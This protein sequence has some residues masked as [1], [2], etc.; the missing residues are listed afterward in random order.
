MKTYQFEKDLM[1]G[2]KSR[3]R[4]K[5]ISR[6]KS[7]ARWLARARKDPFTRKAQAEGRVSRAHFKLEELDRRCRLLRPGMRV[8]EL[9]AAPGGWT[10]YIEEQIRGG[11]LITCD[12]R[13][14]SAG[15]D[16]IVVEGEFGDAEIDA[17]I[18]HLVGDEP[19][20]LVLSD[21]SPNIS[22]IRTVD[23]ALSMEL[24]ELAELAADN[25][26]KRNGRLVIKIF[27]GEGVESWMPKLRKKYGKVRLLKPKA[28]RSDSREVYLVAEQYSGGGRVRGTSPEQA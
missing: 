2:T 1:A 7:S 10:R 3:N 20:D 24:A 13:P 9:G 26:L 11:L 23:Q 14:V 16:T 12:F 4:G 8:L 21:M 15:P 27:Q 19:L 22:G 6:S 17:Q 28:S 25:W 5:G 18:G